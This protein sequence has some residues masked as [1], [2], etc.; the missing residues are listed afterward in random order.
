MFTVYAPDKQRHD[1]AA[2][3]NTRNNKLHLIGYRHVA[4]GLGRTAVAVVVVP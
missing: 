4:L 3:H 1:F 2:R